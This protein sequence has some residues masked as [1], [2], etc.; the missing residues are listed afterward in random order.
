M[1]VEIKKTTA[2]GKKDIR[3]FSML[4]QFK[5]PQGAGAVLCLT[6]SPMPITDTVW[7]LP[8]GQI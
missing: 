6:P 3:H 5:L 2:P 8:F 4:D 1:E 7:A